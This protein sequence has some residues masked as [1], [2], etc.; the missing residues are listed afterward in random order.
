MGFYSTHHNKNRPRG[1]LFLWLGGRDSNPRPIGYTSS[2]R[3]RRG[4]DYIIILSTGC[5]ALPSRVILDK[6]SIRIVSEPSS[7]ILLVKGLAADYHFVTEES[8]QQFTLFSSRRFR[9]KL[10][11]PSMNFSMTICTDEDTQIEFVSY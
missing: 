11:Y 4:V 2:S 1:D 10:R 7:H 8:F 3:F 6:Y 5:K 9:R